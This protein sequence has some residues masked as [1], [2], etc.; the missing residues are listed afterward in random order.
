M[1]Q[2]CLTHTDTYVLLL[3]LQA[4]GLR[5][6]FQFPAPWQEGREARALSSNKTGNSSQHVF[7]LHCLGG[8][9]VGELG[10]LRMPD[11]T[12]APPLP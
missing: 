4:R 11:T 9:Q 5:N 3:P 1:R 10:L 6:S 12:L 7:V 8:A 2:S